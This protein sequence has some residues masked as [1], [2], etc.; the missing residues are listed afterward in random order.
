MN[1]EIGQTAF[2]D[3]I[4]ELVVLNKQPKIQWWPQLSSAFMNC[5]YMTG[6]LI[7]VSMIASDMHIACMQFHYRIY[8]WLLFIYLFSIHLESSISLP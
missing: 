5:C 8:F 7:L 2:K 6:V 3:V 1:A 4:H